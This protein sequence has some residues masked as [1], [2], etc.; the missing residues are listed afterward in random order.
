MPLSIAS[1]LFPALLLCVYFFAL[2][3]WQRV[4]LSILFI[5]H[6]LYGSTAF[7]RPTVICRPLLYMCSLLYL[8]LRWGPFSEETSLSLHL[9]FLPKFF[10][11]SFHDALCGPTT[12]FPRIYN[13]ISR[14]NFK[15]ISPYQS[16]V[17]S[18]AQSYIYILKLHT[19]KKHC[20]LSTNVAFFLYEKRVTL[21]VLQSLQFCY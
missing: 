7:F 8:R 2:A 14:A 4:C 19:L 9:R 13:N 5:Y 15:R 6:V 21:K 10:G 11:G 17:F 3:F 1:S 16:A 12:M 18:V 20:L